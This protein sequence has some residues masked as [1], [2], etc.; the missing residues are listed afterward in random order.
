[1]RVPDFPTPAGERDPSTRM[2]TNRAYIIDYIANLNERMTAGEAEAR[3]RPDP[4]RP[5]SPRIRPLQ[6]A[7]EASVGA[8]WSTLL[9]ATHATELD[10]A[11]LAD[12]QALADADQYASNIENFIGTVRVPVG[13]IGPLRVNGLHAAGDFYVPLATTEAALVASYG[14]G[15]RA[16]SA[17]GGAA[18]ALLSEGVMRAPVFSFRSIYEA[19]MFCAWIAAS[20]DILREIRASP[21]RWRDARMSRAQ[22]PP[23]A[24]RISSAT[25]LM[26]LIIGLTAGPAV[27][28]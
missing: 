22:A 8:A 13:V 12:P 14:R 2:P 25:M 16:I 20:F 9:S 28:L 26:I 5:S 19:G 3:L 7:N 17:A 18:A 10:K 23:R 24:A 15:A 11:L 27:S 1:M 6:A 21:R 4:A